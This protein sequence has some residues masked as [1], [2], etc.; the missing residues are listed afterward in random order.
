MELLYYEI[1]NSVTAAP[2]TGSRFRFCINP[3]KEGSKRSFAQD[4]PAHNMNIQN[5]NRNQEEMQA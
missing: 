5:L 2:L 1:Q 4:E 3:Q